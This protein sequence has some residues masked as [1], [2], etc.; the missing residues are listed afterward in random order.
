[1]AVPDDWLHS[2]RPWSPPIVQ[3]AGDGVAHLLGWEKHER[4]GSWYALVSCV[5]STGYDGSIW[6]R[7]DGLKWP[8]LAAVAGAGMVVSA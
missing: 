1:M 8:H 3:L 7:Y 4:D 6:P 2:H 5:Q